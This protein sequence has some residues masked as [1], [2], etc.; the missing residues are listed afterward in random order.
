MPMRLRWVRGAPGGHRCR[1]WHPRRGGVGNG[2]GVS[3][4]AMVCRAYCKPGT[5]FVTTDPT[6]KWPC[7]FARQAGA[8]VI[9]IP[10]YDAACQYR[11]T[12]EALKAACDERTPLSIWWTP[13]IRLAS[14]TPRTR[15]RPSPPSPATVGRCWSMIVHTAISRMDITPAAR[16]TGRCGGIPILLQMAGS[17]RLRIGALV[18]CPE[19]LDRCADAATSVLGPALS[20]RGRAAGLEVKA[21]WMG[22]CRRIDRAN[23]A[24]IKKLASQINAWPC[25][26]IPPTAT[27]WCW[28]PS[29]PASARSFG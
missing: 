6:W 5:T 28:R 16:R 14:A 19:I 10:I 23:K 11:L 8:M 1:P 21:E 29:A 18:A 12:P 26:S 17:G 27:S 24:K 3:A 20:P 9:E 22:R 4:L 15:S 25:R 2:G 7:L 13:T